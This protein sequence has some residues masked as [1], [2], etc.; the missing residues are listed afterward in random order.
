MMVLII[1]A[2]RHFLRSILGHVD[3]QKSDNA[4][5]S[6]ETQATLPRCIRTIKG[7]PWARQVVISRSSQ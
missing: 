2:S 4:S 7:R 5:G 1:V 3:L 6:T